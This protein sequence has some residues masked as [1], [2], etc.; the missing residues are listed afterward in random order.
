VGNR[1]IYANFEGKIT[2]LDEVFGEGKQTFDD[3]DKFALYKA[4][5]F[6]DYCSAKEPKHCSAATRKKLEA[7]RLKA[8]R[9]CEEAMLEDLL[10]KMRFAD[11]YIRTDIEKLPD[12]ATLEEKSRNIKLAYE[13][14]DTCGTE[15]FYRMFRRFIRVLGGQHIDFRSYVQAATRASL[16][17][18]W[19]EDTGDVLMAT[20]G[21]EEQKI[22]NLITYAQRL[23]FVVDAAND[24]DGSLAIVLVDVKEVDGKK[25]VA[26][27]GKKVKRLY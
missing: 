9:L 18:V 14:R 22:G 20:K 7:A 3:G 8:Q 27:S 24:T 6:I 10:A 4:L 23:G 26:R 13:Y 25:L 16:K 5:A 19:N 1:A 2:K 17:K 12:T 21:S 15:V 11:T